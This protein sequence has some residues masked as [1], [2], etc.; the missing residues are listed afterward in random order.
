M[1]DVAAVAQLSEEDLHRL[2]EARTVSA[3]EDA[4]VTEDQRQDD[5]PKFFHYVKKNQIVESAV[6]G[7]FV[8]ALCGETFPVTKQAKPGSP[9]C[10]DCEQIYQ[11][12]RKK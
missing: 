5:T 6:E 2:F 10:P 12:L 1:T 11:G 4:E 8:V 7:K 9:V 3:F